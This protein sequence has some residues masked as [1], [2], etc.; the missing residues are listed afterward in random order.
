MQAKSGV[1][2]QRVTPAAQ[3]GGPPE[4]GSH[5]CKRAP[6]GLTVLHAAALVNTRAAVASAL[7]A[8]ACPTAELDGSQSTFHLHMLLDA[9]G[10]ELTDGKKPSRFYSRLRGATALETAVALGHV[11]AL[12]ALLAFGAAVRRPRAFSSLLEHCPAA[13]R[14]RVASL[15]VASQACPSALVPHWPASYGAAVRALLGSAHR[16]L[17]HEVVLRIAVLAAVPLSAW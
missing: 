2:L 11:E 9:C 7:L 12:A 16:T 4:A 14:D 1:L 13:A 6:N 8:G 10:I 3:P 5:L 15:L 17:P